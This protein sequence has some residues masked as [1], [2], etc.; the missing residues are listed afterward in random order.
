MLG[1]NGWS[2]KPAQQIDYAA[3]PDALPICVRYMVAVPGGRTR[4]I[5]IAT[6]LLEPRRHPAAEITALDGQLWQIENAKSIRMR[7]AAENS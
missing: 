7:G 6:R 2:I 3:P 4:V 1:E 5:T